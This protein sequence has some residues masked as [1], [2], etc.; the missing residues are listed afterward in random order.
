MYFKLLFK[1]L[2]TILPTTDFFSF[3]K[4][5]IHLKKETIDFQTREPWCKNAVWVHITTALHT[6][7]TSFNVSQQSF[8][9]EFLSVIDLSWMW[10]LLLTDAPFAANIVIIQ[11]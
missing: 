7:K 10:M 9:Q 6:A 3:I 11:S 1:T 4:P 2:K 5:K 8:I